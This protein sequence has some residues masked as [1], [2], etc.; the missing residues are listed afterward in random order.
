[1]ERKT[2]SIKVDPELWKKL[3][4]YCIDKDTDVSVCLDE[5]IREKLKKG[6]N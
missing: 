5:L 6:N 1:M 2:T 4:K 3:K